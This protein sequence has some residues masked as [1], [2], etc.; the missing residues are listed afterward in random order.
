MA[1]AKV[2]K[3]K[4]KPAKKKA[5]KPVKKSSVKKKVPKAKTSKPVKKV[6]KKKAVKKTP[7]GLKKSKAPTKSK[8]TGKP[9][10]KVGKKVV[11]AKKKNSVTSVKKKVQLPIK[12]TV[13]IKKS[14]HPPIKNLTPVRVQKPTPVLVKKEEIV[15]R[16]D[17]VPPNKVDDPKKAGGKAEPY[18][19]KQ[20]SFLKHKPDA[21][22]LKLQ[23]TDAE[24]KLHTKTQR[25]MKELEETMDLDKVK[26]RIKSNYTPPKPK[27]VIPLKLVEP[28][29]TKKEKYQLE[30]EFR[31]SKAI[32]FSYLSDSSGMAGWFA[33]EVKSHDNDY[34]F[35]WEQS[36]IHAKLVALKDLQLVRFQWS[37][38]NDGTYFQFEI[39]EDDITADI[40]LI[41]TD[42]ANP[43]EKEANMRL[44]ESQVQNLRQLIGSVY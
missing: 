9:I 26:P 25:I 37:D 1:K 44:W 4:V 22:F 15:Q 10:K 21:T 36:E 20:G 32:L 11:P 42:W 8:S 23:A 40:A 35:I 30:F 16:H 17:N 28:T 31:S 29:N 2:R 5:V 14:V 19:K 38:E 6:M 18:V 41:I 27:P 3:T 33:E 39:K 43:G 34:I 13:P 7:A 12:K 24:D